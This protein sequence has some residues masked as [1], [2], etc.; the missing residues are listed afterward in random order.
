MRSSPGWLNSRFAPALC[1]AE[2]LFVDYGIARVAYNNRHRISKDVWRSAQPAPHHVGWLAHRGVKTIVNLRGEQSFGT[3][4]LEQQA[5]ARHGITLVDLALKSR[6]PPTRVQLRAMRDL[7]R[8]VQYPILV[9]CKSGA[10]RAG[11]MSV[12]VR[13]ERDGV[14]IEEA[15]KQLSLRYGHVRS[16]DTGVLDAVFQRYLED[17]AKTG[18]EFWDWVETSYDPDQIRRSFKARGW[19]NRLVDNLLH[20]E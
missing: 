11:L 16:A 8:S 19:A 6:A 1:Y 2:M 12:I 4:W 20:R 13:H 18:V 10:D 17:K 15:R 14:P 5:C 9:H 7:L 3:R